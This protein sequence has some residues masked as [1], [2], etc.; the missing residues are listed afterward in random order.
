MKRT[1][2]CWS[3]LALFFFSFG[4]QAQATFL[5][6]I[7]LNIDGEPAQNWALGLQLLLILT[8]LSLAPSIVIM[9][10]SFTRIVIVLSL[11]RS[12]LATQRM[13]PNQ[14]LVGM[15]IFLTFFIMGPV[16]SD[17]NEHALQ[18]YLANEIDESIALDTGLAPLKDFMA[19]QTDEKDLALFV[20]VA[21]IERP[22]S[23]DDIPLQ[24]LVPAFIITELKKAFQIGFLIYL[25][26]IIIDMIVA[27]I[28]MGMGM[29]MLPPVM[30][31]LPF[32]ILL[33]VL[34]DG[35]YLV[36]KSLVTTFN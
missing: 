19:R 22:S 3:I 16:F 11:L 9:M 7:E 20:E 17:I 15:A 1:I 23:L 31:S 24:V 14:V 30:I 6:G 13:P 34:V 12:A 36:I 10:T 2:I 5:P 18:P 32:K 28:L 33:F 35:W 4:V 27:S 26:F 29:M 8:V 25:P 21:K